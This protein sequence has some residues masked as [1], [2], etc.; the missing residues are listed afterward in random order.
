VERTRTRC[1]DQKL[2]WT[3]TGL[4]TELLQLN[5][6]KKISGPKLHSSRLR[7]G[8]TVGFCAQGNENSCYKKGE[9]YVDQVCDFKSQEKLYI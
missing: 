3:L 4:K 2:S 1:K 5:E 9:E 6:N 7:P 8:Q